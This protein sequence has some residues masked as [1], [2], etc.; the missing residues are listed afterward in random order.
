MVFQFQ[1]QFV[2]AIRLQLKLQL[3]CC[4]FSV[5]STFQLQLKLTEITL[6]KTNQSN[7]YLIFCGFKDVK[8]PLPYVFNFYG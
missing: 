3:T 2:G 5:D 6:S 7:P 8:W 1:L 4:Y